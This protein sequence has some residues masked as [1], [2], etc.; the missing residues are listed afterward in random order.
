MIIMVILN[1]CYMILKQT[2]RSDNYKMGFSKLIQLECMEILRIN[3][4]DYLYSTTTLFKAASAIKEIC[5]V[6]KNK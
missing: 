4:I 2:L 6:Q 1:F 3:K 5:F